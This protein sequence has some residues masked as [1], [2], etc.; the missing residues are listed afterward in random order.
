MPQDKIHPETNTHPIIVALDLPFKDKALRLV[1]QLRPLINT[2]K[3]GSELFTSGG[4]E[5][6]R[7]IRSTGASVFLDLKFHDIPHTV[8]R[9]AAA[10]SRLDVTMLTLHTSGGAE[11][12]QA[13]RQAVQE[14]SQRLAHPMPLLLG[15]TVLTSLTNKEL[16]EVGQEAHVGRQV[17]RLAQLAVASGLRGLVCSPL[18]LTGLRQIL[19]DD[20]VLVTPGIRSHPA[21][22]DDQKRTLTAKE[23]LEAGANW[24]VV[25]R[26]ITD[27]PDPLTAAEEIVGSVRQ[28]LPRE[29]ESD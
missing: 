22:G 15:V 16:A 4:P 27:A 13:A 29:Q 18:E 17:E 9:A 8:A 25:G 2:F 26:P 3:I 21:E 24:I 11:M 10:A 23:A 1:D 6:V 7:A 5:V 20:M 12:L 28:P 19:P 14:T